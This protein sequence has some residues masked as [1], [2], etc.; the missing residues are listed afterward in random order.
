MFSVNNPVN[1]LIRQISIVNGFE[2]GYFK[3]ITIITIFMACYWPALSKKISDV[4]NDGFYSI[5]IWIISLDLPFH[6]RLSSVLFFLFFLFILLK[7]FHFIWTNSKVSMTSC[8]HRTVI[9]RQLTGTLSRRCPLYG[10]CMVDLTL[11]R[12]NKGKVRFLV[13]L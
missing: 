2:Y 9:R 8:H 11:H 4:H 5:L 7:N 13:N 1:S 6:T 3:Q 10:K 12:P